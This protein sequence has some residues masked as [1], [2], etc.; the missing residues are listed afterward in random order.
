[1]LSNPLRSFS[2]KEKQQQQQQQPAQDEASSNNAN[3]RGSLLQTMG[4][5]FQS[6][7]RPSTSFRA[8][9]DA[10]N[11]KPVSVPDYLVGTNGMNKALDGFSPR[12][13][14]TAPMA[15]GSTA[16]DSMG[17]DR[18]DRK[19]RSAI[20]P[21]YE[22]EPDNLSNMESRVRSSSISPTFSLSP[23]TS[24]INSLQIMEAKAKAQAS[25]VIAM[26]E[27]I[28]IRGYIQQ[29]AKE[30]EDKFGRQPAEADMR[31]NAVIKEKFKDLQKVI[32]LMILMHMC[33]Y[34]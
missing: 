27:K 15:H 23:S 24:S 2:G 4:S 22:P 34:I 13:A 21:E 25:A 16:S 12:E 29:W 8:D 18:Y 28:E 20:E 19:E 33:M 32:I 3:R 17:N 9:S 5:F 6:L 1:M 26:Q 7:A 10:S 30:F 14:G 11:V 31:A